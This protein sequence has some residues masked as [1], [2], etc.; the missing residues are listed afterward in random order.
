MVARDYSRDPFAFCEEVLSIEDR[1]S[2]EVLPFQL[3]F[4]QREFLNAVQKQRAFN[5]Y[6]S[7]H[8]AGVL[9]DLRRAL[10]NRE[11]PTARDA[12]AA[13]IEAGVDGVLHTLRVRGEDRRIT[14][15]PVRFNILKARRL[16]F[17]SLTSALMGWRTRFVEGTK[18]CVVA[19][20]GEAAA[21][22]LRIG[23][24]FQ[25]FWDESKVA[26][27]DLVGNAATA[28]AFSNRSRID[29][30]TAGAK[31]VRSFQFDFIHLSEFAFYE[32]IAAIAAALMGIPKH[33]WLFIESTANGTGN[34]FHE[35]WNKSRD[36]D[37]IIDAWDA[38]TPFPDSTFARYFASW[39][40]D[41][42]YQIP[43]DFDEARDI[44]RT[45]SDYERSLF[46]RFPT[47]ATPERIKWWRFMLTEAQH[48]T[49]TPEQFM[50]QEYPATPEEAFQNAGEKIFDI[51]KQ[52]PRAELGERTATFFRVYDGLAI[53]HQPLRSPGTNLAIYSPPVVGE[54]YFLGI[55][56]AK[57]LAHKDATVISVFSRGDGLRIRQVAEFR[58]WVDQ[59]TAGLLAVMLAEMYNDG[60]IIQEINDATLLAS[61]I[62]D[63]CGYANFYIRQ[64]FDAA[65]ANS[66]SA[67]R[68]GFL[69]TAT[70]KK[71]LVETLR[72]AIRE[73]T[74]YIASLQGVKELDA[75][76]R[77]DKG[78]YTAPSGQH[79]DC[80]IS[81]TLA[82]FAMTAGSG[83]PALKSRPEGTPEDRADTAMIALTHASQDATTRWWIDQIAKMERLADGIDDDGSPLPEDDEIYLKNPHVVIGR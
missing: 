80:V 61:T 57:G 48:E 59:T 18:C 22:V 19:H 70:T 29:V 34:I 76:T 66:G 4:A 1:D 35:R 11:I 39:L 26:K 27:A 40:D 74:I 31:D 75:F 52:R 45:L 43:C 16:G 83:A 20:K 81:Y 51:A 55:D 49:L 63:Q 42:A 47:R 8:R 77:D 67:F 53:Q 73:D 6:R 13:I 65:V 10:K 30:E 32:R 9:A 60:F 54:S 7:C 17:T 25:Q 62:A 14:D 50:L 58:G 15:S 37:E 71:L 44:M 33:C 68:Y 46:D 56:A 72:T 2:N 5:I 64:T 28:M 82:A 23:N 41:P 3:R 12:V 69:T 38:G 79:D 36:I 24:T 21:N 78:R